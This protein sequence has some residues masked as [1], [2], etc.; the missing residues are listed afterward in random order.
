MLEQK[1][2][3][4]AEISEIAG[5]KDRQSIKD[6]LNTLGICGLPLFAFLSWISVTFVKV[7]PP[8][9]AKNRNFR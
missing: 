1:T 4:K 3:T 2:Y 6:K 5:T 7:K 9:T 8:K